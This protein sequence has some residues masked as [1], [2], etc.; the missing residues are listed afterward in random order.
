MYITAAQCLERVSEMKGEMQVI[1]QAL[2]GP[3]LRGGLVK[4]MA[5]I[6]RDLSNAT[7]VISRVGVPILVALVTAALVYWTSSAIS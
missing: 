7:G 6:K 5:D 4:D 3:D 2:V 1:K